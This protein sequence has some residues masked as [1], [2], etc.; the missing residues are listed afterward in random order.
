[1]LSLIQIISNCFKLFHLGIRHLS[2]ALQVLFG[3]CGRLIEDDGLGRFAAELKAQ[4][5]EELVFR[6]ELFVGRQE[7]GEGGHVG[8]RDERDFQDEVTVLMEPAYDHFATFA[9]GF[10][11]LEKGK[12]NIGSSHGTHASYASFYFGIRRFTQKIF[13][14]WV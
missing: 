14:F 9:V 5:V 8:A 11:R 7:L 3:A 6:V 1:M 10:H 4:L 12:L 2:R 13:G